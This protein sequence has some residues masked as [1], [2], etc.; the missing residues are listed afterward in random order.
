VTATVLVVDDDPLNRAMLSMSL[1]AEGHAVLEAGD[2]AAAID[3]LAGNRVDLVLTDI[4]MPVL[5]G[6]GL[7]R[8]RA[9]DDELRAIPFIVLSG[10]EEM[11]SIVDCIKLG[12]EDY[13]HKP[14]DPVLLH[15]RVGACLDKKRMT[16]E[17]RAWNALLSQR[18]EE[19]VR[20][21]ERLNVLRRFV[22]PQL[23]EVLASD[24]DAILRSHR[25]E[26]TVLFCDLRGFTAFSETA[27]P[28]EVM[29]VL[30]EFH[31]A[32]GPMIF[33][34]EGTIAQFTGDGM[35]VFFNDPVPCEEPEWRA[36]QL[37]GAMRDR[38]VA[39]SERWRKRGHELT[40]GIGIA[41]GFATCGEIGFDG[42]T[43]YT[44]I[45]TVVNLAAR[46][47][48]AAPGGA[49]LV[50]NRVH[51]AVEDRV[52]AKPLGDVDFKGLTRP[53]PIYDIGLIRS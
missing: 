51:A 32:V 37:A 42:R 3:L 11:A 16:D 7:L 49:I 23:A 17:L 35:L 52:E 47:C 44:A 19:G 15:A 36:V 46:V 41:V 2:G 21:V 12:A 48:G 38:T 30:R 40:L 27:E 43:E 28:E 25:R 31:D 39:L 9:D 26:I 29:G 50:T 24:G 14:F 4:E 6:Y 1:T 5:D 34:H 13:L 10:V 53:V 8:H 20:E 22:T 18:V 45:G 33:E